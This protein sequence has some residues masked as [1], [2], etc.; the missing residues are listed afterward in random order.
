MEVLMIFVGL[1]LAVLAFAETAFFF[2]L[3]RQ[4]RKIGAIKIATHLR[5]DEAE[6]LFEEATNRYDQASKMYD[7]AKWLVVQAKAGAYPPQN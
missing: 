4:V 3:R 5:N 6:A 1:I 7:E 2:Y